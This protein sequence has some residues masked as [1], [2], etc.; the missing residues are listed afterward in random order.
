MI[1]IS[2]CRND[3]DFIKNALILVLSLYDDHPA[4]D[5]YGNF[6]NDID[7]CNKMEKKD[8]LSMLRKELV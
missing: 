1:K 8:I 2:S 7:R 6:G 3:L 4:A 5:L